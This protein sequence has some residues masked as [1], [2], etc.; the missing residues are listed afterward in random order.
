MQRS[1]RAFTL[2]E[3]AISV[4]IILLVLLLAVP[5]MN[6][7][8]ADRNLRRSLDD[9]NNLVRLAQERSV[10]ERRAY[11]IS[12]QKDHLVLRREAFAQD[13]EEKPTATMPLRAGDAF[14]LKLPAALVDDP[15]ADW[16]FWPTGTC[17]PAIV[18]FKGVHGSWSAKYSSLTARAELADYVAN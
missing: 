2:I 17:E 1:E 12:W 10:A 9:L 13:E 15:P 14:I 16:I 5:S 11:L 4:F 18:T 7:V 6:G 8:I 3:L